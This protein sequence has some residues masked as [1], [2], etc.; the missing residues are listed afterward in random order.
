MQNAKRMRISPQQI[1][2]LDQLEGG[3]QP[4]YVLQTPYQGSVRGVI[5]LRDSTAGAAK[6]RR[7]EATRRAFRRLEAWGLVRL[8]K[9]KHEDAGIDLWEDIFDHLI[10]RGNRKPSPSDIHGN[11]SMRRGN[12][13]Q[14]VLW[15]EITAAG[16]RWLESR[17]S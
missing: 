2:L 13:A 9:S 12:R 1:D 5:G 4:A 6:K 10:R 15:A 8:W 3:P 7:A 11:P 14:P 16:E 17:W